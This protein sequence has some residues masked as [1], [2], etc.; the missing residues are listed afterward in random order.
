MQSNDGSNRSLKSQLTPEQYKNSSE[1]LWSR[2]HAIDM[3]FDCHFETLEAIH[4][5][6]QSQFLLQKER[7]N[8]VPDK[9][10][11]G[12]NEDRQIR[13]NF[14]YCRFLGYAKR[15][16][17]ILPGVGVVK[18]FCATML[19]GELVEVL[20]S[21]VHSED[22]RLFEHNLKFG[23][24]SEIGLRRYASPKNNP[25]FQAINELAEEEDDMAFEETKTKHPSQSF[26]KKS[27][28]DLPTT[29]E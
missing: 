14:E 19:I 17:S 20:H 8:L 25:T 23:M 27:R 15:I 26:R 10:I 28:N 5:T 1:Q 24:K 2:D 12:F 3:T 11:P 16:K 7:A 22:E 4:D 13:N 6:V 21:L 18:G 9:I 29:V